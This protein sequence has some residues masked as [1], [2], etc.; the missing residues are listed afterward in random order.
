MKSGE[1][2]TRR[3]DV[4]HIMR[5]K[6][7]SRIVI[8]SIVLFI[9]PFLLPAFNQLLWTF[10][11][12]MPYAFLT[13]KG[14]ERLFSVVSK[15]R[16]SLSS[17]ILENTKQAVQQV[18]ISGQDDAEIRYAGKLWRQMV[19]SRLNRFLFFRCRNTNQIRN[20]SAFRIWCLCSRCFPGERAIPFCRLPRPMSLLGLDLSV[21]A[22]CC[23]KPNCFAGQTG[24]SK[25]I[26]YACQSVSHSYSLR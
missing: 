26:W 8:P 1:R 18:I 22:L 21:S 10:P 15:R 14:R 3:E 5:V 17:K 6:R 25:I 23:P 7:D 24:S 12:A 16:E 19:R 9:A 11:Q 2:I 13:G 20:Q 4:L